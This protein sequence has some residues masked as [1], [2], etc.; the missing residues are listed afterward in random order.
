M[1]R[2]G[3]GQGTT[4]TQ[5]RLELAQGKKDTSNRESLG[6][7]CWSLSGAGEHPRDGRGLA[8]SSK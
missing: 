4:G 6:A 1:H 5:P 3:K 8:W 2:E 7:R